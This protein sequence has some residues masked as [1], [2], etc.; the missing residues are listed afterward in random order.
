MV[1]T[2]TYGG[3]GVAKLIRKYISITCGQQG[4]DSGQALVEYGLI[5]GLI[6]VAAMVALTALGG[7]VTGLYGT[8]ETLANKMAEKL[9]G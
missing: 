9:A 2:A 5:L 1:V 7:D 6:A 8:L 4:S 3:E